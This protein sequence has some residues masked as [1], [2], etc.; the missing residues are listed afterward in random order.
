MKLI[1]P[2]NPI[3][4]M[5]AGR[6]GKFTFDPQQKEKERVKMEMFI[7]SSDAFNSGDPEIVKDALNLSRGESF[8]IEMEF[9]IPCT[10]K[11]PWGLKECLCK[12][13]IDNLVKFQC[14]AANGILY[15]DDHKIV[16]LKAKKIYNPIP[17]TIIWIYPMPADDFKLSKQT[18]QA[19][20]VISFE[21]VIELIRDT[22]NF[23]EIE[24]SEIDEMDEAVFDEWTERVVKLQVKFAQKW[25]KKLTKLAAK[26]NA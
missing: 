23:H 8:R 14:D 4:K 20:T 5:R 17:K 6:R 26:V 1:I 16:E 2:G 15:D 12:K 9:H 25:A 13:D 22:A 10:K 21:D 3:A 7:Q 24:G 18:R 11:D 19:L